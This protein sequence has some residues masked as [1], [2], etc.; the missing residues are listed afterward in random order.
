MRA[1]D[2]ALLSGAQLRAARSL[3]GISSEELARVS[4]LGVATIRR[5]E[6]QDGPVGMTSRNTDRLLATLT[7]FGVLLVN[8]PDH[9]GVL[10]ERQTPGTQKRG[11]G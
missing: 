10:I 2:R 7:E 8:E 1:D 6:A 3:I 9:W 11:N 5:A 4:G